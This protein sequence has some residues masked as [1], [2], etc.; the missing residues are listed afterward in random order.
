LNATVLP[1]IVYPLSGGLPRSAAKEFFMIPAGPIGIALVAVAAVVVLG[2]IALVLKATVLSKRKP[3]GQKRAALHQGDDGRIEVLESR[4]IDED[5]KLVLVRCDG[6]EHLIVTGGPNDLVVENDVKKARPQPSGA[7][8]PATSHPLLPAQAPQH[9]ASPARVPPAMGASLDAAIAAAVSPRPH[10]PPRPAPRPA[11]E[12]RAPLQRPTVA[13][14]APRPAGRNGEAPPNVMPRVEEPRPTVPRASTADS[15]RREPSRRP[16]PATP[17]PA[18]SGSNRSG[19][20][21]PGGLPVAQV[22]WVEPT[23]IEDEIVQALRFEPPRGTN[24]AASRREPAV[25]KPA[26]DSSATLGDLAD[27]LE[28]ALAREIQGPGP[29]PPRRSEPEATET[30]G[31]RAA[32]ESAESERPKRT[33]TSRERPEKRERSEAPKPSGASESPRETPAAE[34]REEAPVISLNARRREASD[35]LEDEMARLLGELTGDTKGR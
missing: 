35:P 34:R 22:P 6:I 20:A 9:A 25:Q 8:A 23:S 3:R 21:E 1:S 29:T 12:P 13:T 31:E 32:P 15:T 17:Q 33:T 11:A 26:I 28:E 19:R 16:A 30:R 18:A 2:L 10:E 7:R 24:A 5:R 14:V 27:R 4:V